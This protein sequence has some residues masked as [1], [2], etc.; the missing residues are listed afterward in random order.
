MVVTPYDNRRGKT[1]Q[2]RQMFDSIAPAYDFMNRA[3]TLG[4]DK[5]W[6]RRAVRIVAQ[7]APRDIV[8]IATGTGD[9]AIAMARRITGVRLTG[10]DLSERMVEIGRR[11]IAAAGLSERISMVVGDCCADVLP[12]ESADAVTVAYGIRNFADIPRGYEAMR[13]MLRPGGLLCVVELSTPQGALTR[14]LYNLYS[15]HI[16]PAV[17]RVVSRDVRAYSYLPESIAAAP[18]R[19]AMLALMRQAG[20]EQTRYVSLT[21]GA[22]TIY[23]GVRPK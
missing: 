13:R 2:V 4:V 8:D 12:P 9:L 3:M 16:I 17:G 1:E 7:A 10:L 5:L 6:R 18:Q 21:F 14:P 22:C 15:R 11:K 19:D 20:F 23:T